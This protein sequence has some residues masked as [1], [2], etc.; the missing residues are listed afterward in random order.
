MV[1]RSL[2]KEVETIEY[3]CSKKFQ[4]GQMELFKL[5]R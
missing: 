2:V 5:D 1:L 3:S 4:D